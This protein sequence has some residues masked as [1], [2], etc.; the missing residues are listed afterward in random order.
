MRILEIRLMAFG[1]FTDVVLDL[2]RGSEYGLHIIYGPNEAGKSASL[3]ALTALFFGVPVRTADNFIHDNQNLR[4]GARI[5]NS[6]GEELELIRRKGSKDTLLDRDGKAIPDSTLARYLGGAGEELFQSMFGI[7]HESLVR[8]GEQVLKGGGA[9]GESLFAAGMGGTNLHE[10]RRGLEEEAQKLFLPRGRSQSISLLING[11]NEAKQRSQQAS[12]SSREWVEHD[13]ALREAAAM[14]DRVTV[15]LRRA[16][17]EKNRLD[18][19]RKAIPLI[20]ERKE[21]LAK[22]EAIGKVKDLSPAF[23]KKRR[24]AVQKLEN[25]ADSEKAA[26]EALGRIR[27]KIEALVI[28]ENLL[29]QADNVMGLH[30]RLG[31]H[32]KALKD[33]HRL[34]GES[35]QLASDADTMI[36]ELRPD[37]SLEGVEVLRITAAGRTRIRELGNLHQTLVE[38]VARCIRDVKNLDARLSSRKEALKG[39]EAAMKR[40]SS[41]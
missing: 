7:D 4:L 28:P 36:K 26:V 31:S 39:L 2:S 37:V 6:H 24:E 19:F 1:P 34:L 32:R 18:R 14:L 20:A 11:F 40:L 33:L 17:S 30:E 5:G 21:L 10:V 16:E 3:R 29:R 8:G 25:A 22:L 23:G 12:L 38:R 9:V 13:T 35:S 27:Q 15:D 41:K